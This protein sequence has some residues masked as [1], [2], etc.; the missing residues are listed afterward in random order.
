MK[1]INNV[2]LGMN[3]KDMVVTVSAEIEM[4]GEDDTD[5]LYL[6]MFN[7]MDSPLRLSVFTVGKL[8]NL[9]KNNCKC[10]V[11][12]ANMPTDPEA[13]DVLINNQVLFG[14]GKAA[15]AGGVAVSGLEMSQNSMFSSWSREEVDQKLQ[16]IMK[17]IH[18]QCS[19]HGKDG[20]SINYIKGANIGGFIKV[21]DA[22]LDQGC[23]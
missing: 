10:V 18:E 1:K 15:N 5:D 17:S 21:A 12:G 16:I 23:V 19:K 8:Y 4:A 22:M 14:P 2:K 9:V 11:E 3:P 6:V 20:N 13:V 7:I